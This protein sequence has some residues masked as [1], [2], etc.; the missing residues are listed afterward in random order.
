MCKLSLCAN[1]KT[2]WL[3]KAYENAINNS[4]VG[5]VQR[6]LSDL[7]VTLVTIFLLHKSDHVIVDFAGGYGLLVRLL[8]DSGIDA[9]WLDRYFNNIFSKGFEYTGSKASLITSFESLEHFERPIDE[10]S[11][12]FQVSGDVLLS[13][14]LVPELTPNHDQWW[15]YG[16]EHG[17]H[18]GFFRLETLEFIAKKFNKKLL[19]DGKR[20]HL[21]TSVAVN[22]FLFRLALKYKILLKF[23]L[24]FS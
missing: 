20:Y 3:D 8:R 21:F 4:D 15:Y 5:L 19:S 18:I 17:Q 16:K 23:F 14:E 11:S 24:V 22:P 6:N 9:F 7:K 1:G 12:M 10:L 13:T 2:Y